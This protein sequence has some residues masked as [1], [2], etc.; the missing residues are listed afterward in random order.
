M[1]SAPTLDYWMSFDVV[2]AWNWHRYNLDFAQGLFSG[3]FIAQGGIGTV[4][5]CAFHRSDRSNDRG[6]GSPQSKSAKAVYLN[7]WCQRALQ[8]SPLFVIAESSPT[9][10]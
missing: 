7:C 6:G 9:Y 2:R 10:W 3:L 5:T 8:R 4:Q 1:I